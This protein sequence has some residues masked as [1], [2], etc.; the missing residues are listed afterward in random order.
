MGR[1]HLGALLVT[2]IITLNGCIIAPAIDSF[3]KLGVTSSDRAGLLPKAVKQFQ[4]HRFWGDPM[5]A[6]TMASDDGRESLKDVL[7]AGRDKDRIVESKISNVNFSD[8][9]FSAE[10][11][12]DV[13]FYTIPYYVVNTRIERQKWSFSMTGGWQIDSYE[14]VEGA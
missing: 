11:D 10:V 1:K 13:K 5:E 3:K 8:A 9:R 2:V 14:I 12:I 7:L 6:L 4:D